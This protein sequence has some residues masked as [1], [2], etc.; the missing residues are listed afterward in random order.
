MLNLRIELE[1]LFVGLDLYRF[2]VEHSDHEVVF[3]NVTAGALVLVVLILK[4]GI[5]TLAVA[6]SHLNLSNSS[7]VSHMADHA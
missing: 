5:V 2:G 6:S 7:P 4:E 1:N 3:S